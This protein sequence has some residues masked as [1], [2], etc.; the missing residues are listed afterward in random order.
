MSKGKA[1]TLLTVISVVMA[2][3]LALT[4]ARFPVGI[5]NYN[6]VIGAID[7]DYDVAGGV[8]YE[9]TYDKENENTEVENID[10]VIDTL[11][12][13]M[14]ILGYKSYKISAFKDA[15][16]DIKDYSIRISAKKTD[17]VDNDVKAAAAYGKIKFFGGAEENPTTEILNEK[18]AVKSAKYSGQAADGKYVS[19][20]EF[21]D[22]AYDALKTAL[23]ENSTYYLK[24]TLGDDTLLSGS[25]SSDAISNNTIYITTNSESGARQTAMQIATGG[26]DYRYEVSDA[27]DAE[28]LYGQNAALYAGLSLGVLFLIIIAAMLV[29]FGGYG[30]ISALS[31]LF[32][33]LLE[34][35]MLIAVPDIKLSLAGFIGIGFATVLAADGLIITI[36]RVREEFALGKTV[37]AAIKAGYKRSFIPVL[38]TNL[39]VALVSL[40]LFAFTGGAFNCFAITLGIGAVISFIASVL[41]SR[42][43]VAL[44]LPLC[45]D[46]EKF[47]NLKRE[48]N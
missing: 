42:M 46:K 9:L 35:V 45:K 1:T 6:S 41:I 47:L 20:V 4:F 16:K 19:A 43:F 3:W 48:D 8:S 39:T 24:I 17:N 30:V 23:E 38:G 26:L 27:V 10:E 40:I 36:K 22:Y 13:R 5:K 25:L 32:F 29:I 37:K 21:T 7:L 12:K 18:Q 33:A 44:I 15:T 28:P 11:S 2:L 31:V 34:T 14:D